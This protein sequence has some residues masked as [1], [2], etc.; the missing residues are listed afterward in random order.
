MLAV[1]ARIPDA[2]A[3]DQFADR[4]AHKARITEEVVRAE[5]RKAAVAERTEVTARE[6]PGGGQLKASERGLIWGLF[7]RTA[8][9][10]GGAGRAGGR[11][12]SK[13]WPAREVFELARDLHDQPAELLPS[14]LLQRLSTMNAQLVTGIA[15]QATPPRGRCGVDGLRT[16]PET[17]ALGARARGHS[18]RNRPAAGAGTDRARRRNRRAAEPEAPSG[19]ADRTN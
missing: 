6:M 2:A 18:A 19:A 12:T 7:H 15:G 4:I 16:E 1:A 9:G 14:A 3:R 13:T 17:P 11:T 5:I 8:A 10:A